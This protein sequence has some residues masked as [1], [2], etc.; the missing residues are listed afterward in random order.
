MVRKQRRP[1]AFHRHADK[2]QICLYIID[3][4]LH[5]GRPGDAMIRTL[6]VEE[7]GLARLGIRSILDRHVHRLEIDEAASGSDLATRLQSRYYELIIAEPALAGGAGT[8]LIERLRVISP[9]SAV[10]VFTELD[11]LTFGVDAIRAGAR[12][13]LMKSASRD[14][15]KAAVQRV[16]SGRIYLSKAL[17]AEFSTGL[18]RY[19]TRNKPHDTFSRREFQVFS[20]VVCGMTA[21]ECGQVLQVDTDTIGVLRRRVMARLQAGTPQDLAGYATG[22]GL[23]PAC[24]AT[25]SALWSGRYGQDAMERPAPARC[26]ATQPGRSAAIIGRAMP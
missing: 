23:M 9:W 11:E 24:R 13:Y 14:E 19:D 10:L 3:I 16:G 22:Q 18:R 7:N 2:T 1:L 15:L 6:I 5:A 8:A 21:V 4:I 12:G 25:A 17:A 20:M 26:A